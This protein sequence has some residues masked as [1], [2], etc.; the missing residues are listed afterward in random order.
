M[1]LAA[2]AR[3]A[4]II[5]Y[6]VLSKCC[7]SLIFSVYKKKPI[8]VTTTKTNYIFQK[9]RCFCSFVR[10]SFYAFYTTPSFSFKE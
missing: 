4:F 10:L 7:C 1:Q 6:L 5:L 3:K 9:I 8:A 2:Y